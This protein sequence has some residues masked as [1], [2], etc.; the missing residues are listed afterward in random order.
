MGFDELSNELY[1]LLENKSS[2]DGRVVSIHK[3]SGQVM[4]EINRVI[5]N[6]SDSDKIDMLLALINI[7]KQEIGKNVLNCE[8]IFYSLPTI[9]KDFKRGNMKRM[10]E[11]AGYEISER[12][13][14]E[15]DTGK[16]VSDLVDLLDG[17]SRDELINYESV[18]NNLLKD[19]ASVFG[20]KDA[21]GKIIGELNRGMYGHTRDDIIDLYRNCGVKIGSGDRF[22]DKMSDDLLKYRIVGLYLASRYC[23]KIRGSFENRMVFS[24]SYPDKDTFEGMRSRTKELG[25]ILRDKYCFNKGI[26]PF[27]EITSNIFGDQEFMLDAY[28]E[29]S[30]LIESERSVKKKK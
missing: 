11:L 16:L 13:N 4:D 7:V 22:I 9:A 1:S 18:C 2:S 10:R 8:E 19:K 26:S 24:D 27:G 23:D 30:S 15:K 17:Y 3:S 6:M 12:D 28:P 25:I 29:L 14:F 5:R 20:M 21:G